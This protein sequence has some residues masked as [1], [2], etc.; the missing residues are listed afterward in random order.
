MHTF[1]KGSANFRYFAKGVVNLEENLDSGAK[2]RIVNSFSGEKLHKCEIIY[3]KRGGGEKGC[4]CSPA[5]SL[6]TGLNYQ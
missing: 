6:C 2:V 1:K 3:P 5:P 4:I